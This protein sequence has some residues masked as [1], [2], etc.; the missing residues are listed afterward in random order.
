M[1]SG[2]RVAGLVVGAVATLVGLIALKTATTPSLQL[3]P[4]GPPTPADASLAA[5]LVSEAVSFPTVSGAAHRPAFDDLFGWHQARFP[6]FHRTLELRPG[7]LGASRLYVWS[8]SEPDLAPVLLLAHQDVVPVEAGTEADWSYPPFSG[9]VAPCGDWP[10]DC[11]WGRGTLDMKA[12]L[13]GLSWAVEALVD[14]GWTPR[15]TLYFWF[16]DDEEVGGAA[17]QDLDARLAAQGV[18]FAFIL[19]EGLVVTD[20]LVPGLTPPG[21]LV[22]VAEKGYLSVELTAKGGMGHSSMPPSDTSVGALSRAIAALEADP[23]P[24]G[25]DGPAGEM[26]RHLG[27]EMRMPERAVFTNLWLLR[28]IVLGQLEAVRT[29]NALVRTTQAPTQLRASDADNVLPQTATGV[30]NLRLHPRDSMAGAEARMRSIIE[31][32]GEDVTL[33]PLPTAGNTDPSDVS[34]VDHEGYRV[35]SAAIRRQLPEAV[36]APG[37]FVAASDSRHLRERSEAIYRFSP[38]R[39]TPTDVGRI[40][41]TDERVRVDD[42]A[43]S[44]ALLRDLVEASGDAAEQL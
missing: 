34:P 22:G 9:A 42:L 43:W 44:F 39:M 29:T 13:V 16:S 27:P 20:G 12:T 33:R 30:V 8:G 21:A 2:A 26:F 25:M 41:G 6:G 7:T 37:L 32:V 28:G 3:A 14:A 40:H 18:D 4:D 19:D 11:V 38:V 17:T 23:F 10:G 31:G 24:A 1:A 5:T 35:L 36:V 15:R